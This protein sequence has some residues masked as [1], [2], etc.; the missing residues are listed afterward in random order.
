MS[1]PR[2][3]DRRG[4]APSPPASVT[5]GPAALATGDRFRYPPHGIV[6]VRTVRPFHLPSVGKGA[7]APLRYD[8]AVTRED[9]RRFTICNVPPG[10]RF[11][12]LTN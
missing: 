4:S 7:V 9:G 2:V 12:V 1:R 8:V 6:E 10:D 5:K 3:I 11:R